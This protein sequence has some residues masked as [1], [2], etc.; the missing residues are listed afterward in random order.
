MK[1]VN[2]YVILKYDKDHMKKAKLGKIEIEIARELNND[3]KEGYDQRATVVGVSENCKWLTQGDLV[4]THYLGS[5]K[6]NSFQYDG[7]LYHRIR[8]SQIF[9]KINS[10][11]SLEMARGVYL[12]KEVVSEAPKTDSGIYLTP[13]DE[14]KEV[15]KI[16]VTNVPSNQDFIKPGDTIMSSDANQYLINYEGDTIIKID[17]VHIVGVYVENPS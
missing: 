15:L 14:K 1:A 16:K 5:D 10:D 17:D 6:G 8:E 9:F 3:L 4:W 11:G 2:G 7:D 13:F 12:G